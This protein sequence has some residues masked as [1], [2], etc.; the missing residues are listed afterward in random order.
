M[1][2]GRTDAVSILIEPPE[3]L[4]DASLATIR[5]ALRQNAET[6]LETIAQKIHS[7][8]VSEPREVSS[9]QEAATL[10]ELD[11]ALAFKTRIDRLH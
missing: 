2:I 6:I 4:R 7:G 9:I 8:F 1:S 5:E 3:I 11:A 10:T